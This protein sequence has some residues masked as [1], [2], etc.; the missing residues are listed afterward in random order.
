MYLLPE[1]P[2]LNAVEAYRDS[3]EGRCANRLQDLPGPFNTPR[4]TPPKASNSK[5]QFVIQ[6]PCQLTSGGRFDA[7]AS[8]LKNPYPYAVASIGKPVPVGRPLHRRC[9]AAVGTFSFTG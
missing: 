8:V 9:A 4:T 2:S 6:F 5:P 7:L 3:G 1:N